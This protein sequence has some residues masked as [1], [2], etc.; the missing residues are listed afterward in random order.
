MMSTHKFTPLQ[1]THTHTLSLSIYLSADQGDGLCLRD[2]QE[3]TAPR[4]MERLLLRGV[5]LEERASEGRREREREKDHPCARTCVSAFASPTS[6]R[7]AT[8][9]FAFTHS[10]AFFT[11]SPPFPKG[12]FRT[13]SAAR[14][15]SASAA[16]SWMESA[17][18][19]SG[20]TTRPRRAS[21]RSRRNG[22][23]RAPRFGL[24]G[25]ARPER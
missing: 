20:T 10:I 1:H 18:T 11:P 24:N 17:P 19:H 22:V 6:Y 21:R 5:S 12:T 9:A 16:R 2:A 8:L 4:A 3:C 7:S 25:A 23:R 15:S 13:C 14:T